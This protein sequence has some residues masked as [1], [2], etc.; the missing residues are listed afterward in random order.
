ML[1]VSLCLSLQV[2]FDAALA[3][4]PR[5]TLRASKSRASDLTRWHSRICNMSKRHHPLQRLPWFYQRCTL[6]R[7]QTCLQTMIPCASNDLM[8]KSHILCPHICVLSSLQIA[9]GLIK[10]YASIWSA[11]GIFS[12]VQCGLTQNY[13]LQIQLLEKQLRQVQVFCLQNSS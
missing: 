6:G 1:C 12:C 10:W 13:E 11:N 8:T 7:H 2:F 4:L 9:Q 3:P 5:W